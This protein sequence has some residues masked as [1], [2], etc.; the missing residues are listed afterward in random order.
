M[1]KRW[2]DENHTNIRCQLLTM[3]S[4]MRVVAFSWATS[5]AVVAALAAAWLADSFSIARWSAWERRIQQ[6]L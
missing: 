2:C 3:S 5:E 6:V 4:L 1:G